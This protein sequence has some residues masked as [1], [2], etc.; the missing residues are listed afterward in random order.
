MTDREQRKDRFR[1]R[2][3]EYLDG[4]LG[5][6]EEVLIE[7]HLERC[8]DCARTLAELEAVVDRAASLGPREPGEDLWPEIAAR[9]GVRPAGLAGVAPDTSEAPARRRPSAS[10]IA[11]FAPQLAAGIALGWLSGALVWT[12]VTRDDI[13]GIPGTADTSSGFGAPSLLPPAVQSASTL[14]DEGSSAEEYARLIAELERVLFDS[15]RP[16]PPETVARIRRAL[17]TIDRA[18]EDARAALLELPDDPYIQQHMENTMRRKSE[19]LTQAVQLAGT[20]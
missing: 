14:Q 11:R 6:E 4:S 13:A 12:A 3:S 7:R 17:V 19:F 15:E 1:D 20:D 8:E 18:I 16:L 2:L 5:A 9:I 10:R